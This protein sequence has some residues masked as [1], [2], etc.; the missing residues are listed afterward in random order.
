MYKNISIIVWIKFVFTNLIFYFSHKSTF[1]QRKYWLYA[2]WF[3]AYYNLVYRITIFVVCIFWNNFLYICSVCRNK[4][5]A[6]AALKIFRKCLRRSTVLS[7]WIMYICIKRI[8][9]NTVP[10]FKMLQL[11]NN[12]KQVNGILGCLTVWKFKHTNLPNWL[13]YC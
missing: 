13:Q 2:L 8:F 12:G 9:Q 5:Y 10:K 11:R 3:Y 7:I 6:T 4:K 1:F